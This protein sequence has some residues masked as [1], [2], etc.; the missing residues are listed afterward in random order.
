MIGSIRSELALRKVCCIVPTTSEGEILFA[1]EQEP[2]NRSPARITFASRYL[3]DS[4]GDPRG[5]ER[6]IP[7]GKLK[8]RVEHFQDKWCPHCM[9]ES[10]LIR[11]ATVLFLGV[12][13]GFAQSPA[14]GLVEAT[15][16]WLKNA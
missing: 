12:A 1:P 16:S 2:V 11:A 10:T 5:F 6:R 15:R 9:F 3:W 8:Q 4:L 14:D 13:A 7:R